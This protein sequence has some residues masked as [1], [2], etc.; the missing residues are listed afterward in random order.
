MLPFFVFVGRVV[1]DV[2]MKVKNTVSR[3]KMWGKRAIRTM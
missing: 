1:A 2:R 3:L